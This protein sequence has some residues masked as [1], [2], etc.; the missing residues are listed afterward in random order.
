[1]IRKQEN[2]YPWQEPYYVSVNAVSNGINRSEWG[3]IAQIE[4]DFLTEV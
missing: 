1:M 4:K 3:D 2:L